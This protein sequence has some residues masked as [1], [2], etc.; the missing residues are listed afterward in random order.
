MEKMIKNTQDV[1]VSA[2]PRQ[3][4]ALVEGNK[5]PS[6]DKNDSVG[7][8]DEKIKS[9]NVKLREF[10]NDITK[11]QRKVIVAGDARTANIALKKARKI[12]RQANDLIAELIE[13]AKHET[14]SN[15]R[16]KKGGMSDEEE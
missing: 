13:D 12:E 16:K 3:D 4:I 14:M 5:L 2:S 6:P 10:T 9:A 8:Q 1:A 7:T 11:L 15:N